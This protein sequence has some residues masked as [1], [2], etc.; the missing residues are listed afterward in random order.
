MEGAHRDGAGIGHLRVKFRIWPGQGALLE[1]YVR[2]TL[3]AALRQ[4]D[5]RYA[6][7]MI[8]AHYRAEPSSGEPRKALPRPAALRSR[9][10][11]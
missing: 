6:D 8:A 3:A 11:T 5:E 4:Y 10:V 1:T 9:T 2:Q 7:W